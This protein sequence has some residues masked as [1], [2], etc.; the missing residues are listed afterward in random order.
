MV[1][2]R[3]QRRLCNGC[4]FRW[5]IYG[6]QKVLRDL[7]GHNNNPNCIQRIQRCQRNVLEDTADRRFDNRLRFRV[8]IL[9]P[10]IQIP[11]RPF[12]EVRREVSR[13]IE[14][15]RRSIDR[16]RQIYLLL[17]RRTF[18]SVPKSKSV[19]GPPVSGCL[20]P[21]RFE[22]EAHHRSSV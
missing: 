4:S 3:R 13:Q 21:D 2:R 20:L 16:E 1:V 11:D 10:N 9:L 19:N 14:R 6:I 12:P 8:G 17:L 7:D 18:E 15:L 5:Y 22:T